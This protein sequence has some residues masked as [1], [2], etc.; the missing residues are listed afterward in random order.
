MKLKK[1]SWFD[2]ISLGVLVTGIIIIYVVIPL[3]ESEIRLINNVGFVGS[4]FSIA[5]SLIAIIQI[6]KVSSN[7][8]TYE[9]TFQRTISELKN[10]EFIATIARANQQI[11][12][13]KN[14]FEHGK[15]ENTRANFN[16]LL[17]DIILLKNINVEGF[18]KLSGDFIDF[19][20]KVEAD[21]FAKENHSQEVKT[22]YIK[23]TQIQTA[24]ITIETDI[25]T[26]KKDD[27]YGE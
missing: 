8:K 16:Q 13:I 4:V 23:L 14:L 9:K 3:E 18:D 27:N 24:L 7:A 12:L 10:N 25:K 6:Y 15:A 17:M 2:W 21:T 22:I 11:V 5:G 19:L 26:P 20:S 1:L